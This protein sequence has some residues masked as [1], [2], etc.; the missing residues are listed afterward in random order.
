MPLLKYFAAIGVLL[1]ALLVLCDFMFEQSKAEMRERAAARRETNL[2]KPRIY[3]RVGEH[4]V[5]LAQATPAPAVWQPT[6]LASE[7]DRPSAESLLQLAPQP[8]V[9]GESAAQDTVKKAKPQRKTAKVRT[10]RYA[11]E[12]ARVPTSSPGFFSY[13]EQRP[14]W[15]FRT[16]PRPGQSTFAQPRQ[17]QSFFAPQRPARPFFAQR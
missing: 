16:Q 10:R 4:A 6:A 13:A 11:I 3:S 5:A 17:A 2:P 1:T 14:E 15:P 8:Q 12:V 9:S 7:A